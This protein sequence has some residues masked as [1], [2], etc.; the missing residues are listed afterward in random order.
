MMS[1]SKLKS[2]SENNERIFDLTSTV[3]SLSV[4]FHE[5]TSNFSYLIII[6]ERLHFTLFI[7]Y[8]M[9]SE[10]LNT[11]EEQIVLSR[12]FYVI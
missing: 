10:A 5:Y 9:I 7:D 12:K 1:H 6:G 11:V 2:C 8:I 4:R 3:Y